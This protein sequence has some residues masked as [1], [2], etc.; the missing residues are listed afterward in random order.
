MRVLVTGATGFIG[1]HLCRQLLEAGHQV[2]V[3]VRPSTPARR[4]DRLGDVETVTGDVTVPRSLPDAVTGANAVV[5][6][7]GVTAAA[8]GSTY[9][10]VNARGT[11]DLADTCR[12]RGLNRFVYISS[13]A[14]QGPSRP[15]APHVDPGNEAPVNAYG[16]SKLAAEQALAALRTEVPVTVLRPGIVYG[17]FDPELAAWARLARRRLLPVVRGVELS[18]VHVDDLCRLVLELLAP[19]ERPFGPF[20]ISDGDPCSM[21]D[22]A[23][24]LERSLCDRPA[25]RVPLSTSALGLLVPAVEKAA[26]LVGAAP[27]LARTLRELSGGGWACVPDRARR[28]LGFAPALPFDRG[29]SQTI[30]WYRRHRWI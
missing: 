3:L 8:R 11:A 21:P 4:L 26:G 16:R 15:G 14:A 28:D 13:L 2:R 10:R 27:L 6:L 19:G 20:F 18:F 5:H 7:A 1:R 9:D 30:D 12:S 24:L 29:L 23:D 17:P 22:L 25:V